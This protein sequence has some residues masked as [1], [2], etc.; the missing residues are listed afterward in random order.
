MELLR[1]WIALGGDE[2]SG[3]DLLSRYAEAHRGYHN[4]EHLA[5]VLQAVDLLSSYADDVT[6]VL[7]AAFWHD[8]VYDPTRGDNEELSAQ[9]AESRLAQLALD[10]ALIRR[11]TALVRLTITHDPAPGD[12]D[13][14]V[15]CDADL[16]I[17]A[18]PPE[19][20]RDY[21]AGVRREYGHVD[22][23]AF[24][25]GR[26]EVLRRL[27]GHETLYRTPEARRRWEGV[28]RANLHRELAGR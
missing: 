16:A 20:Y 2:A 8:A 12:R 14:A 10:D 25:A 24:D 18:A 28:A 3:R 5:E 6:A 13:G 11:V 1:R 19:R 17:L 15:L 9:L 7:L 21:V 23:A 26:A 22:D 27:L 4:V